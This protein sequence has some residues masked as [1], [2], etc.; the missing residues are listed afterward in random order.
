MKKGV[1][2]GLLVIGVLVAIL[3]I[4]TA[5]AL[6]FDNSPLLKTRTYY[7]GGDLH[8]KDKGLFTDTYCGYNGVKDT[9]IKGFSYSLTFDDN[10]EIIDKTQD[11]TIDCATKIEVFYED[12][13]YTYS[14]TCVKSEYV[15]VKYSGGTEETVK[16]ALNKGRIDIGDLDKFGIFYQKTAK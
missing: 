6:I 1:K 7:D 8:Y 4:D 10:F 2:I 9:V 13:E 15:I 14:F 5:Q 11:G 16:E 3:I 12:S